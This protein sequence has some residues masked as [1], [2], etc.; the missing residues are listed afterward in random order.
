MTFGG[1]AL[2]S[3]RRRRRTWPTCHRDGATPIACL[4]ARTVRCE[5]PDCG[6]E[7]PLMRSMWLFY[8][9]ARLQHARRR[10]AGRARSAIARLSLAGT[11]RSP[12][13]PFA[14]G[15]SFRMRPARPC[16]ARPAAHPHAG[17]RTHSVIRRRLQQPWSP[18][19]ALLHRMGA[20]RVK[21][22]AAR[23][24]DGARDVTLENDAILSP[25][26]RIRDGHGGEQGLRCTGPA[27]SGTGSV[28]R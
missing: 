26:H 10:A 24:V 4:W 9:G 7:I 2:R 17:G 1:R 14:G 27:A 25:A 21:M 19:P 15:I 18:H 12:A 16:S 8:R 23:R 13:G 3:R 5:A 11:V 20:A 28:C 22:A 6:A